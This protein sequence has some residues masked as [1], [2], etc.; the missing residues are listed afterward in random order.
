MDYA[1]LLKALKKLPEKELGK[2]GVKVTAEELDEMAK[3]AKINER[4]KVLDTADKSVGKVT[5]KVFGAGAGMNKDK[6]HQALLDAKHKMEDVYKNYVTPAADFI[7][8]HTD[9][10]QN[11]EG[12]KQPE[13]VKELGRAVFDP[14]NA[15]P[16]A[17]QAIKAGLE[18]IPEEHGMA[19][20]G[21]PGFLSNI[22][23]SAQSMVFG[24][25]DEQPMQRAAEIGST[26]QSGLQ[27]AQFGSPQA[28][29]QMTVQQDAPPMEPTLPKEPQQE[30]KT[31]PTK[32]MP[33]MADPMAKSQQM[34][35][36]GIQQQANAE[37]ALA[38]QQAELAAQQ[39]QKL[40]TFDEMA[41]TNRAKIQG[42]IEA[43][44]NDIKAGEINP[45]RYWQSK[46]GWGK[47]MTTIGLILGGI[48][49]DGS[50][51]KAAQMLQKRIDNDI[52]AQKMNLNKKQSL[53]SAYQSYLKDDQDA[54]NMAKV[55]QANIYA[56]ELEAAAAKSRDP[57]AQAR[58]RQAAGQLMAQY[59]PM[60]NDIAQRQAMLE[61]AR[62]GQLGTADVI[63][64]VVP[65]EL[66]QKAFE[67][68]TK[69]QEVQKT[70]SA[71]ASVGKR[72][73]ELQKTSSRAGSPIQAKSEI[74]ALNTTIMAKGKIL[75]Q[76]MSETEL[77]MMR[78]NLIKYTD[79]AET[80][81][82]KIKI[83]N[84]LMEQNAVSPILD[85]YVGKMGISD[86]KVKQPLIKLQKPK[87]F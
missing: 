56:A 41:N 55:A 10:S 44:K 42:E 1:S 31:E 36:S 18:L 8:K 54:I 48:A 22:L 53:L 5:G 79:S 16:G 67:E 26:L 33:K 29:P 23:K 75:F 7:T 20:G 30:L 57:I 2:V 83:L 24:S 13:G 51:N 69:L 37:S 45:E 52:E 21:D 38:K 19:D 43:L 60:Q 82:R 62:R 71:L 17:A 81:E 84:N 73:Y 39:A 68:Q 14:A 78:A 27:Q 72:M 49:D 25:S 70:Q 80:A 64:H 32:P 87:G 65:K 12:Y 15:L 76:N 11:V 46:D 77:E 74:D 50:G 4:P 40:R 85:T 66:K 34:Q 35:L 86:Y 47:A 59:A 28:A 9:P 3:M 6:L 63:D 58:A 61:M